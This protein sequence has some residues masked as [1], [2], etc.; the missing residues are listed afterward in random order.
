MTNFSIEDL[1]ERV[2]ASIARVVDVT[3]LDLVVQDGVYILSGRVSTREDAEMCAVIARRIPGIGK[4]K[5]RISI[6]G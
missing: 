3:N 4:V 1:R 2:F 6:S 5:N